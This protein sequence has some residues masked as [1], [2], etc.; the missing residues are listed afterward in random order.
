VCAGSATQEGFW[1]YG[2]YTLQGRQLRAI[3]RVYSPIEGSFR[4]GPHFELELPRS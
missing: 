4:D 3:R 1:S 2:S